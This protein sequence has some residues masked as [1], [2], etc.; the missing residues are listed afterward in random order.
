MRAFTIGSALPVI[1]TQTLEPIKWLA[2]VLMLV[3]HASYFVFGVMPWTVFF[4]GRL[5]FPLFA[6]ALAIG[7]ADKTPY[8]KGEVIRRLCVWGLIAMACGLLVRDAFPLNVLFTFAL[9]IAAD[10][11]FSSHKF[12]RQVL[13]VVLLCL[14]VVCE[15]GPLG[16]GAVVILL[17]FARAQGSPHSIAMLSVAMA[18]ICIENGNLFALFAPLVMYALHAGEVVV[19]RV[20][21]LFYKAYAFQWPAFAAIKWVL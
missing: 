18:C 19:P 20:R 7:I 3:E 14:G 2:L 16:V 6:L 1:G 11:C 15:F 21:G 10:I 5:V 12:A 8:Q 4:L 13:G 17:M 9:A